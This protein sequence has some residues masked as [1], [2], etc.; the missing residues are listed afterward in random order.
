MF[1]VSIA[2]ET[3]SLAPTDR[4]EFRSLDAECLLEKAFA[5]ARPEQD[6]QRLPWILR[7]A[8]NL[9]KLEDATASACAVSAVRQPTRGATQ[10]SD[11]Y[12]GLDIGVIPTTIDGSDE[13]LWT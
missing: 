2:I 8:R 5:R 9:P 6:L 3:F 1:G 10:L 11:T 13:T 7:A 12:A 4:R